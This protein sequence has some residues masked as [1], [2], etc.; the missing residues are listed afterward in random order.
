MIIRLIWFII[1]YCNLKK[2]INFI[3]NNW[4]VD[5]NEKN[6]SHEIIKSELAFKL[7][8]LRKTKLT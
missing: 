4:K 6:H 7:K 1:L 3:I 5:E 8:K 2:N